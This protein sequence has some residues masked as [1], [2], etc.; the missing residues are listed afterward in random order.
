MMGHNASTTRSN[1][2]KCDAAGRFWVGSMFEPRTAQQ[3]QL[4]CWDGRVLQLK[5]SHAIVANALAFSP[6]N[7]IV[8]WADTP[9]HTIWTWDF[10]LATSSMTNQRVFKQF[11]AMPESWVSGLPANGGYGGRPDGAAVDVQGNLWVAMFEGQRLAAMICKRF[12][13]RARGTTEV[14]PSLSV[15]LKWAVFSARASAW[16]ACR[17]ISI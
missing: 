3:A 2:G 5:Q 4:L 6:D 1:D 15:S 13:S 9:K 11:A 7:T 8:Y 10:D 12:I 16:R 14:R 17:L